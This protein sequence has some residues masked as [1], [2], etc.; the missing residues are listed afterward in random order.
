MKNC[1]R[2]RFELSPQFQVTPWPF[3]D[4]VENAL[5][6]QRRAADDEGTLSARFD[7]RHDFRRLP[8]PPRQAGRLPGVEDIDEMMGHALA[9]F[10]TWLGGADVHAAIE[11]HGVH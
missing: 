5:Q 7:V 9:I 11:G 3:E 4:A 8:Q 10:Y 2:F 1:G 6:V